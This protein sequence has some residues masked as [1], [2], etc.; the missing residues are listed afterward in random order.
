MRNYFF[1]VYCLLSTV[2]CFGQDVHF[3]QFYNSPLILNPALTGNIDG[4]M[5]TVIN[6][7]SQWSSVSSPFV[8]SSISFDSRLFSDRLK[9]DAV[10]LGM[11][12][13][14][15]KAGDAGLN[16]LQVMVNAAYHH[17]IGYD[18]D[19]EIALGF[20]GGFFQ[21]RIDYTKLTFASQF[22]NEDFNSEIASG[23]NT[24]NFN[25]TKMDFQ[26]GILY[27]FNGADGF[28][29]KTG[30]AFFHITKPNESLISSTYK[31]PMR[32]VFHW[33]AKFPLSTETSVYP[34]VIY[35]SQSGAREVNMGARAEHTLR[36]GSGMAM[37]VSLGA[38]YRLSDAIIVM[39]GVEYQKWK[40]GVS[41]DI[42]VSGFH[43]ASNYNG[44]FEL[45]I[46]YNNKVLPGK[47]KL[48]MV[49][50]CLRL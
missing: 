40:V 17:I 28:K 37:N 1:I 29:I 33:G 42:N 31:L 32:S 34:D 46:I 2:Y 3:S 21:R 9:G 14:N 41:Y 35:M 36:T 48:P 30:L 22:Q 12:V 50:P 39:T 10:G 38:G 6:H 19:Q 49:V 11:L 26:T 23:E 5:R 18:R 7:R 27:L 45:S 43:P 13:L 8:T 47:N 15:D 16:K 20:Q 24:S 4:N 44:G 25:V